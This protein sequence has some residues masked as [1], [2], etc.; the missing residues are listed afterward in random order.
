MSPPTGDHE[1]RSS[2]STLA[3]LSDRP[4]KDS[5]TTRV[6]VPASAV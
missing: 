5:D 3:S 1:A 4:P 6:T 2:I